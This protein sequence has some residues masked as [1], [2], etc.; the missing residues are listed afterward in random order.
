MMINCWFVPAG[1]FA[2]AWSSYPHI[3]RA[4]PCFSGL[5]MGFGFCALYN[6]ANN[7]I[8]DPYQ[9]YSASGIVAK[10]LFRSLWDATIPLFTIQLY[11]TLGY[12]WASTLMAFILLACCAIPYFTSMEQELENFR[13][14]HML[15]ELT[16]E[17][18]Y[19]LY[20]NRLHIS[21]IPIFTYSGFLAGIVQLFHNRK[22]FSN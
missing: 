7:Y 1:L 11:R 9:H 2:F 20:V 15:P 6:P 12:E 3:S 18:E 21:L 14:T 16:K 13:E 17:N 22:I 10:T 5:L 8:V 19:K 4:G